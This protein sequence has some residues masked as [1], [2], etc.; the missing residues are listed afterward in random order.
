MRFLLYFTVFTLVA[1]VL[2][3]CQSAQENRTQSSVSIP[4]PASSTY[5]DGVRRITPTELNNLLAKDQAVVIDVRNEGAYYAEHI[6]GAKLI[7]N[8]AILSHLQELP[9]N[10]LIVTYCS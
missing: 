8:T 2:T 10:K 5:P 7:P 3:A 1:A 6:K 9:R 4:S